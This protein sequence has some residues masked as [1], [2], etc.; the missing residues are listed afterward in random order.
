MGMQSITNQQERRQNNKQ[1]H[2]RILVQLRA[3]NRRHPRRSGREGRLSTRRTHAGID[4]RVK[5]AH[6]VVT[7]GKQQR[8]AARRKL[9]KLHIQSLH[10][11]NRQIRFLV[12]IGQRLNQRRVRQTGKIVGVIQERLLTI[13]QTT[14]A[15]H[16]Q[17]TTEASNTSKQEGK[18]SV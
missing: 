1:S 5:P 12:I 14:K 13:V 18:L 9:R 4:A 8:Q 11:W 6:A 15:Q 7:R 16:R 3:S 10:V 2:L 17:R